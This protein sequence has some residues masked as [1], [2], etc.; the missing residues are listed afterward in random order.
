MVRNRYHNRE[1]GT[2][3]VRKVEKQ[4]RSVEEQV[5]QCLGMWIVVNVKRR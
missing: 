4:V 3:V 1:T 5:P 2:T